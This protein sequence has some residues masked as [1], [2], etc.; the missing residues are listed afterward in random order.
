[1]NENPAFRQGFMVLCI[2]EQPA[3]LPSI[4]ASGTDIPFS[5]FD[6]V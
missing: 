4:S 2:A 1:M 6:T 3:I 5:H